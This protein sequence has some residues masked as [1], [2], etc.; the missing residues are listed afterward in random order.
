M[1]MFDNRRLS[2]GRKQDLDATLRDAER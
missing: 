1:I 2:A